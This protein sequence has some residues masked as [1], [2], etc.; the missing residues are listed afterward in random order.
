[1]SEIQNLDALKPHEPNYKP[2][3][4]QNY[5]LQEL[6]EWVHLLVKRSRHRS[7]AKKREKDLYDARNY[8]LMMGKMLEAEEA[9]LQEV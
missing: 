9:T 5:T 7:D 4:W 1:M 8:Y 2:A 3:A 6:G